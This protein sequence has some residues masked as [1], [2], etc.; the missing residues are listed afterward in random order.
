M[1][2]ARA[3]ID[4][5]AIAALREPL[6]VG[7]ARG[8]SEQVAERC[9]ISLRSFVQRFHVIARDNEHVHGGLRIDV[10]KSE[11]PLILVNAVGGNLARDDPAKEASLFR[12]NV[13]K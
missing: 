6:L 10:T 8:D 2:C 7:D 1:A 11:A 5:C 4:Y 12:H 3:R 13:L 9:F